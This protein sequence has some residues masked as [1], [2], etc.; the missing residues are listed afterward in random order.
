MKKDA[1]DDKILKL[2]KHNE[3][4]SDS[5]ISHELG[6]PEEEIARRIARFS[7]MR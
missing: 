2:I 7:D 4:I 5:E 1:I 6:I 3:N